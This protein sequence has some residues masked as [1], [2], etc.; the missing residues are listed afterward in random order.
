MIF[1]SC[2]FWSP[3]PGGRLRGFRTG[4]LQGSQGETVLRHGKHYDAV[5][6]TKPLLVNGR[7]AGKD[8]EQDLKKAGV[9][10]SNYQGPTTITHLIAQNSPDLGI[11]TVTF[12][13]SLPQYVNVEE[14]YLGKVRLLEIMNLLYDIPIDKK[15]FDKAR[16]SGA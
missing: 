16:G 8:A 10:Q 12:I 3:F 15:D 5:P 9:Q 6:H 1:S 14:D 4:G 13:V 11:E 7:A 2:D